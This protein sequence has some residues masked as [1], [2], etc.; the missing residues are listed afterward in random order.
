MLQHRFRIFAPEDDAVNKFW[1]QFNLAYLM[2]VHRVA[3][4]HESF[5]YPIEKPFRVK[6]WDICSTA[7][8]K[9]HGCVW[10]GFKIMYCR[11]PREEKGFMSYGI[12]IISDLM[13][14]LSILLPK[15]LSVCTGN[16]LKLPGNILYELLFRSTR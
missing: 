12:S 2:Y 13:E 9:Y 6:G 11:L 10:L 8:T 4:I 16:F 5:F 3:N 14:S 1:I 15:Y 7:H